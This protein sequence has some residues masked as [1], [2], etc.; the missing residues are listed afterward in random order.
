MGRPRPPRAGAEAADSQEKVVQRPA[1][2]QQFDT[3]ATFDW[4]SNNHSAPSRSPH[5]TYDF[6]NDQTGRRRGARGR[7]PCRR[8]A[9]SRTSSPQFESPVPGACPTTVEIDFQPTRASFQRRQDPPSSR[10]PG[11]KQRADYFLDGGLDIT[12]SRRT[13]ST[14]GMDFP[15]VPADPRR[16]PPPD[17]AASRRAGPQQRR[18]VDVGRS[19][20]PRARRAERRPRRQAPA[21]RAEPRARAG[22]FAQQVARRYVVLFGVDVV[23][24]ID[25]NIAESD[26]E[27]SLTRQRLCTQPF[28]YTADNLMG[29]A[30][31]AN[32]P[33]AL[34]VEPRHVRQ[35]ARIVEGAV[36]RV[37]EPSAAGA[38]VRGTS[39][40]V[41]EDAATPA[42]P[43]DHT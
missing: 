40:P 26:S 34:L 1:P 38:P 4:A 14:T 5:V 28:L 21:R 12:R 29:G 25:A 23:N 43:D 9:D 2:G 37:W 15:T 32:G 22:T 6:H 30:E 31:T 3:D 8:P 41:P 27:G 33:N 11:P 10:A 18:S 19:S 16:P 20:T 17:R 13:G 7:S 36:G 42:S 39:P 24:D 35:F